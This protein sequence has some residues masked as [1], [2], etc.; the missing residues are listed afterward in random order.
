MP[1]LG[2]AKSVVCFPLKMLKKMYAWTL[3]WAKTPQAP[4]ALFCVAFMESSFFP[5]PPDVLLIAMVIAHRKQW[6]RFAAICTLGSVLGALFGYFI[7]WSLFETVGKGII[8]FYHL[9]KQFEAVGVMYK[10][11][12]FLAVFLAAFT[13]I[14][15][16]VFAIAAGVFR[17][18]ILVLFLASIFGRA[19]RFFLV[20]GLLR[21][22]GER[23]CRFIEK[24][25][26]LLTV[27]FMA[28]VIGGYLAIK[29]FT[30]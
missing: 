5:I 26:D 3:H 8:S 17:V 16:K 19:G 30:R 1:I 2:F 20:A 21:I 13:P 10:D 6:L 27:V 24:Y 15:Y 22:F 25:F 29:H 23:V 12:A 28:M 18:S 11:N 9:E 4:V 14:P 7:G